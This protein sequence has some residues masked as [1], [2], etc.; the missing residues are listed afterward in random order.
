MNFC[1]PLLE[2][3]G[4]KLQRV[5]MSMEK[6][7]TLLTQIHIQV[8]LEE[9]SYRIHKSL[10]GTTVSYVNQ[11]CIMLNFFVLYIFFSLNR[12]CYAC[13]LALDLAQIEK[14]SFD[15]QRSTR[16]DINTHFKT[17]ILSSLFLYFLC[18][19]WQ[20]SCCSIPNFYV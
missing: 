7:D 9:G 16:N 4:G 19:F 14:A 1:W 5:R 6:N 15:L 20:V 17:R 2:N 8:I 10:F 3:F 12:L 13:S 18:T 11:K